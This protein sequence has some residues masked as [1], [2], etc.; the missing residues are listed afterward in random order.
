MFNEDSIISENE[1]KL[2]YCRYGDESKPLVIVL[3]GISADQYSANT[4]E[5][6]KEISGWWNPFIGSGKAVDLDRFQV[7]SIDYYPGTDSDA[8]DQ[9]HL[10]TH[11]QAKLIKILL[12]DL[13]IT[14]LKAVIGCSFGG[15]VALAF[16]ELYPESLDKL[17]VLCA[18]DRSSVKSIGLREIQRKIIRLGI[19]AKQEFYAVSLARS[20]AIVGYRGELE[21]EERFSGATTDVATIHDKLSSYLTYNGNKF[22]S[23]FSASKYMNLSLSI[24]L[25]QIDPK[26]I[27][28]TSLFIGCA[29][30]HLV[31]LEIIHSLSDNI[32]AKSTFIEVDSEY[33]H[34]FF[35]LKDEE[36]TSHIKPFLGGCLTSN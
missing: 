16:A 17:I 11:L 2:S 33:G 13:G 9:R 27:T 15:M 12:K 10:R 7:L 36:I 6:G 32:S 22:A 19:E 30:D 31:P 5:N 1:I 8:L 26:K 25:H 3:G 20:L 18:A 28:T 23:K 4:L 35:L 34:D 24:D 29:T 14:H 21:M